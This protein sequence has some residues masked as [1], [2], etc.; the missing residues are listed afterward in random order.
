MYLLDTNIVSERMKPKPDQRVRGWLTAHET[1]LYLSAVTIDELWFGIHGM[2][3]GR[4]KRKYREILEFLVEGYT[5]K[6]LGFGTPEALISAKFR[7]TAKQAG[8]NPGV[9]DMMI[10]AIA[11]SN[12]MVLA[13]RNVRDFAFL[14]LETVNPFEA[15]GR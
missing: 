8:F 14:D 9:Q 6:T 7:W 4:R 15:T 3:E 11:K 10:A 13:T 2:P 12:H 1:D 5:E